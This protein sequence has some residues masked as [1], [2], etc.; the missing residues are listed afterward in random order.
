MKARLTMRAVR[1][2]NVYRILVAPNAKAEKL[3][4]PPP[5]PPE[6]EQEVDVRFTPALAKE[7]AWRVLEA[8][9]SCYE[10]TEYDGT[11]ATMTVSRACLVD[12]AIEVLVEYAPFDDAKH[13]HALFQ[14]RR[15]DDERKPK[16]LHVG[17]T[18]VAD[19]AACVAFLYMNRGDGTAW[20][21]HDVLLGR[22]QE[23]KIDVRRARLHAHLLMLGRVDKRTAQMS[24]FAL[25]ADRVFLACYADHV[26]AVE[27]AYALRQK[28][29]D[30]LMDTLPA[31]GC[32]LGDDV[33][34]STPVQLAEQ[35]VRIALVC[36][37][38]AEG[39]TALL[40]R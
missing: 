24:A 13:E 16:R 9:N 22:A 27:I 40:E 18:P 8:D 25:L 34:A 26:Q 15:L 29:L 6:S 23:R 1:D 28:C 36:D 5:P 17:S 33:Q 38:D 39:V 21:L 4:P 2:A 32:V 14:H 30:A 19:A 37:M 7:L 3:L 20:E 12:D 11:V 10:K 31:T 35:P